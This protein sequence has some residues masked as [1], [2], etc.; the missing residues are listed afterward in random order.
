MKKL[1]VLSLICLLACPW[2]F[3]FNRLSLDEHWRFQLGDDTAWA[4]P[5]FDDS[6]WRTLD[7]PHDWSI[8]GQFDRS[9]PAGNDGAYLPTGVAWYRKTM[10]FKVLAKSS[11]QEKLYFEGIYMNSTVYLNGEVVGGH[12]YGYSSFWVDITGKLRPGKNVVAV[13]VDNSAQKNCR[14]YSGSGIYRHVWLFNMEEGDDPWQLFVRT[15]RIYGIAPDGLSADSATLRISY[16]NRPD[17]LRTFRQVRLWSPEQP[18]LYDVQVGNLHVEH[19]FRQLDYSPQ[20]LRL[21]GRPYRLYGGCVHHDHGVIGAASFDAA[22]WRKA[23]QLK[24]A[25]FNA[26][27]TSHNPCSEEFLRA[28]DHLG[29]LVIDEAFDGLRAKKN[30]FDY[31]KYIDQWWQ[32]DVDALV[33]RDRNHPC[34]IAWSNGNELYERRKIEV[35]TTSRKIARRMRQLDPTRPVTQALCEVDSIFD[36]LAETLDL[37]GYNYLI[38]KAPIDHL[39]CPERIIWQTE[40][41]PDSA[42]QSWAA[43]NDLPYVIG[44]FVWTAIDYLGESGI[45]RA[46]YASD[47]SGRGEHWEGDKWPWHGSY[48]G[49]IDLTGLRK[50]ISYYRQT[51][52]DSIPRLA[53][54]VREPNL[55]VDS[56]F[57]TRW[58]TWPTTQSWDWPGWE[59]KPIDVELYTR[60]PRVRLYLNDRLIGEQSCS[61]Q[62][63]FMA[64]FSLPYQSGTLRAE[65]LLADGSVAASQTLQTAGA[66]AHLQLLADK[67]VLQADGQ[68]LAFVEVQLTDAKG[69]PVTKGDLDLTF[70]LSGPGFLL[71]VGNAHLTD[72]TSYAAHLPSSPKE[73]HHRLW[74]GRALVVLRAGAS[75]G[76][77]SLSV[78]GSGIKQSLSL[79]VKKVKGQ[80]P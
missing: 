64:T 5:S 56:I 3:A 40:S 25:G 61:R 63:R 72:S 14:W 52:W 46:H 54:G 31:H 37:V 41:Y 68:D 78:S 21:N 26:V 18:Y 4:F 66:P 33:L 9:A 30:A 6:S 43:A 23:R 39:R 50:P 55:Y 60:F 11:V 57:C 47:P 69:H 16:P 32:Q 58:S 42:F 8:E 74:H 80:N 45:G 59:G 71:G 13:R 36:P 1:S 67:S 65:A 15:E 22:E 24:A 51:L 53:I 76:R 7:L 2:A 19:G 17:E 44:D 29:L 48:C 20:G 12:P 10:N 38:D 70:R 62:T 49:D 77:L 35:I 28:C 75:S 27:R 73:A 79:S 34:V